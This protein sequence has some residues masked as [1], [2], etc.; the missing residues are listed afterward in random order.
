MEK[1][2]DLPSDLRV[3]F[4]RRDYYILL[5][6]KYLIAI[7]KVVM[8]KEEVGLGQRGRPPKTRLEVYRLSVE[9]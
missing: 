7:L 9:V 5:N 1:L 6:D 4:D 2:L 3:S 8:Q